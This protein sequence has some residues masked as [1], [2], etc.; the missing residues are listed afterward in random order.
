MRTAAAALLLAL[1]GCASVPPQET[2]LG[3]KPG[4]LESA[5]IGVP[6]Q[7]AI[8]H[9]IWTP[10]LDAGYVPQGLTT[11]DNEVLVAAYHP[12][13]DLKSNTGPCRVF[14][15]SRADGRITGHFDMPV[16]ACTHA[17]GLAY[18]GGGRLLLADTETLFLIDLE[19]AL[20]TQEAQGAM[21]SLRLEGDLRGS[22]AA[23]DGR[24][25]WIG[26]WTKDAAKSR[27]YRLDVQ[28]FE[29][30]DG[31]AIRD[32]MA[33]EVRTVPLEAQGA[34]FDAQGRLWVS[35]SNSL[36]GKLYRLAHDGMVE[37]EYPMVVGLEDLDFDAEGKL[38]GVSESGTRKY[39]GWGTRFPFVFAMDVKKLTP[40]PVLPQGGGSK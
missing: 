5:S 34:A 22:F 21:K 29:Q 14:R 13:P 4:Y 30:R 20:A 16:G 24:D 10:G 2:A 11:V 26:T 23:F 19:R 32:D 8:L 6:N 18:L 9:T 28:L 3:T 31:R 12:E 37:A 33:S 25:P 7:Q 27:M 17:G 38:W 35:A 40:T 36:W 39:L 1:A 15:V